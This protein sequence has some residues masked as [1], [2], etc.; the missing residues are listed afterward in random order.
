[1]AI[2][3]NMKNEL[4]IE[5]LAKLIDAGTK[6]YKV[7]E[8]NGKMQII[9]GVA[10]TNDEPNILISKYRISF[11]DELKTLIETSKFQDSL[12]RPVKR[13]VI[14]I[15]IVDYSKGNS[16]YFASILTVFNTILNHIILKLKNINK[17]IEQIIPSGDGCYLVFN[18]NIN[19]DFF[20]IVLIIINEM[21]NFQDDVLKKFSENRDSKNKLHLRI[22]CTLGETDFFYDISG[23]RNCYGIGLNEASRILFSGQN[24]ILTKY[25]NEDSLDS[26]FFDK[27]VLNQASSLIKSLTKNSSY[28]PTIKDLGYIADKHDKKR[29]IWWLKDL[30]L[31]RTIDLYFNKSGNKSH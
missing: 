20:K 15:D 24:E 2:N 17:L 31:D 28:F 16:L 3:E 26:V 10:F 4:T 5:K 12:Y 6:I 25:S 30:P 9:E 27:T 19:N 22:S 13:G 29:Q 11:T 7:D 14:L 23:N 1:M 18:E 21:N 8:L